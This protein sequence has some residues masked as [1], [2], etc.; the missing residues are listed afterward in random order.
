MREPNAEILRGSPVGLTTSF[1]IVPIDS[2]PAAEASDG[3]GGLRPVVLVVDD[4]PAIADELTESLSLS[5]YAAI[6]AYD[7]ETA[8]ET[9]LL[10]PPDLAVIDARLSGSTG[11]ELAASLQERLPDCRIVLFG[12]DESSSELLASVKAARLVLRGGS[13]TDDSGQMT[14]DR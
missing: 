13:N 4:E 9:A 2:I 8:L 7:V 5:G 11:V 1:P 10:V 12:G 3:A 6:A 14:V